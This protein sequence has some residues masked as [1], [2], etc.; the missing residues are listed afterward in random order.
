[1]HVVIVGGGMAGLVLARGLLQRGLHPVVV[2]RS[3]SGVVIEGPIMLPFQAYDALEDLG[4]LDDI[5]AEGREVPPVRGGMPVAIG[6]GR[7]LI[8]ERLRI[9]LDIHWQHEVVDLL[10][11]GERVNGVRVVGPGG[12]REIVADIVVGADGARSRVRDLAGIEADVTVADTALVSFRSPVRSDEAFLITFTSDGRQLT[13]LDWPGGSAGSWQI[14]RPAGGASEVL[15]P[16][17]EAFKRAYLRLLPAA[18][19]ALEAVTEIFYRE[20]IEVRCATWSRPGVTLIGE[21]LHALNPE[22][23]IGSGLGMGDAQALAIAIAQNHDDADGALAEYEH[24]RRPAVDPYI[25][26]GSQAVRVVRGG[27]VRDEERWPPSG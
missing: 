26:V 4:L 20:P 18:A 14:E 13:L 15:A 12:E 11:D 3:A 6:V 16:G 23:G 1:M 17:V 7:Q 21:A 2:E 22:A 19:P 8:L 10:R 5:R 25:A 24:W 27:E 9:G